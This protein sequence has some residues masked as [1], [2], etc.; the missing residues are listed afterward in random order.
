MCSTKRKPFLMLSFFCLLF[1]YTQTVFSQ[2]EWRPV[3]QDELQMKTPKVEAD[4]DAEA[5]FWEVKL[6]DKKSSKLTY[7]HYVRVKIFTERGRE[8]FSKFDIPF[9]KG[10]KIENVAARVI[11]PD[12]SI[13]ALQP[14]DIF[15][16]DII[17]IR[18][19]KIKA[20]SF[21]VP[22]IEP[23]VIVEYQYEEDIKNDS[24]SGERLTFQRDIPMQRVT[25]LVRPY[26]GTNLSFKAYNM[27][28]V[29]FSEDKSNKGFYK[30]TLTNVSSLKEEPY[31]PPDDEVKKWVYL[32]YEGLG[33]LLQ[34][35]F[36]SN[37]YSEFLKKVS[38]PN[39]EV[40]QKAAEL[41]GG[42]SSD[43]EKLR[44]IYEFVQ[45]DIKNLSFDRSLSD[46]QRD[47]IKVKDADDALKNRAG[48]SMYIDLLF[49]SL[50]RA[51]GFDVKIVL[52]GNRSDNFFNPE[53]YPFPSFIHPASIAVNIGNEWKYYN[54]GTPYLP[55]GKLVWYEE[56][57]TAMIIGDKNFNW[58]ITPLSDYNF[59]P[60]KRTGKF[61][62]AED[63][64]LEGTVRV[65]Y[66]GHQAINRRREGYLESQNKREDD[67]KDE[68]KAR[69]SSAEISNLTIENF[70][71]A[72][73]PLVYSYKVKVPNYAQKTGKRLFLQP[74]FFEY[75]S[76][77]TFSSA[78]R[79]HNIYFPYPW[80]EQD[81]VELELPK[82]FEL[83]SADSPG[84]IGD[85]GKI[86]SLNVRISIDKATNVLIY[87]RNF[88][89]GGGGNILFPAGAYQPIKNLFDAFHKADTH[90]ITVKQK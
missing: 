9:T 28:E 68:V 10:R 57:T 18:K 50:A 70:E 1:V 60:A 73:K 63:G 35:N 38:K 17:T 25:Y 56:D 90:T 59:S 37:A 72:A 88:Y 39:K 23:G 79:V 31:M 61:K 4:A 41:T 29:N 65:E 46:E 44:K 32:R 7:S 42:V 82:N 19:T 45:R 27:P 55:F 5:I 3:T 8:K 54:P 77:P 26:Q 74:G 87:N 81:S 43:E 21:A 86:G 71:D 16:R 13:V 66:E 20:K 52:S 78:T 11:K 22:G 64:T 83:D 48:S 84:E 67:Y 49:A 24:V 30:G 2:V 51:A 80:S 36:L 33:T 85:S 89:F 62:L 14:G 53:K 12:G 75:G 47:N 58:Q 76:N 15:E 34:W 40:K 6:D 69:M